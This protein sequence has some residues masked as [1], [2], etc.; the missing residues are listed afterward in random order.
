MNVAGHQMASRYA[1]IAL[2]YE[3][4]KHLFRT[5]NLHPTG[6]N[7]VMFGP[8]A[9][10]FLELLDRHHVK[11]TLFVIGED[12]LNCE[13]RRA[14]RRF[15]D[16]G[17]EIANHTMTHP[18]GMRRLPFAEKVREIEE[19]QKILEDATGQPIL[20]YK[21]PA[22]DI[23]GD[24]ID[25]LESR[26]FLYD[27][28]VYPSFFNPLLNVVYYFVGGGRPLGLGDWQC[29]LAPNQPYITGRPYW[30]R[31]DRKLIEF[32]ITQIPGVRFPIYGTVMF[33]AG[34]ASFRLSFACIRH[35]KF[36][37]YVFHSF[38]L[39]G[40]NDQGMTPSL[41]AWPAFRHPLA[42]RLQMMEQVLKTIVSSFQPVTYREAVTT[43]AIR[44]AIL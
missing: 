22:H 21:A 41:G 36:L 7:D 4:I 35:I 42:K 19:A 34:L 43:P 31:G 44:D 38:D 2:D 24:V 8:V 10:R 5:L 32:P 33:A 1:C 26:G 16:A 14:L 11:A 3:G 17:H 13:N 29:S 9:D 18:F 15:V 28:S 40:E 39:L 20:G 37:T 23:D 27:A 12:M 25:I 30:R 6:T